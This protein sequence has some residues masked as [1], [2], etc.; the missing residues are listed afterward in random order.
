MTKPNVVLLNP[1]GRRPYLRDYYCSKVSKANY[2]T[3][4]ID[5]LMQSGQ[6]KADFTTHIIDAIAERITA[7]ECRKRVISVDPIAVFFVTGAVSWEEDFAF[8][9]TLKPLTRARFIAS[10]DILMEHGSH[11]LE[12]LPSLD[13]IL[14]DFTVPDLARFLKGERSGLHNILFRGGEMGVAGDEKREQGLYSIP[15]PEHHKFPLHRYRLPYLMYHPFATVLSDY[16]C[17][18]NCTFCIMGTLSHKKRTISNLLEELDLL[19]RMK[20]PELFF[21]D[22]TFTAD[23]RRITELCVE[24]IER[25]YG[26]VWSCWTRADLVDDELLEIMKEAG[27]HTIQFGIESSRDETLSVV[28]KDMQVSQVE[29]AFRACRRQGIRTLGT[30]IIGLEGETRE[31][32]LRDVEFAKKLDCDYVSFNTLVPRSRTIFRREALADGAIRG[33]MKVMDQSGKETIMDVG[34]FKGKEIHAMQ[35]L[36]IRRFYLRPAYLAKMIIGARTAYQ[37]K[38]NII[39]GLF[40][41][42]SLLGR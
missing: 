32:V 14:L 23:R 27:C 36:A 34:T 10:G 38:S 26:F 20:I 12:N 22:Q 16:G 29:Q 35:S 2:Y 42:K 9:D 11:A 33:E 5:L 28:Q 25:E 13:A 4:P 8:I 15:I 7:D 19:K 39:D 31:D 17:P 3:P 30:F 21:I 41:L 24:M 1:P 40:L 18:Y 37:L 6:L